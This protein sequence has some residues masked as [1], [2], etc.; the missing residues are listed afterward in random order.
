MREI[1]VFAAYPDDDVIGCGGSLVKYSTD[2]AI[3]VVYMTSGDAGSLTYTK[4]QL[5]QIREAEAKKAASILGIENLVFLRNPDGYLQYNLDNLVR[6]I[7]LIRQ[8]RPNVIFTHS[9]NDTHA[10]HRVTNQLVTQAVFRA[11][12][13]WFQE[14]EGKPWMTD[15]ILVFEVWTPLATVHYLE[16]V[17]QFMNKK[18]EAL[19]EHKSQIK[20]IRYDEWIEGLNRYR[21]GSTGIGKYAEA[22]EIIRMSHF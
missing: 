6:L 8:K 16:D 9:N 22:F 21:G 20:D 3:T 17:T 5:A 18:L 4:E 13:P 7:N 11:A 15:T 1:L 14:T 10:D 2:N 12:G 19:R